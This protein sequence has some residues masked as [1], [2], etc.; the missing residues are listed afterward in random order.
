M[1]T[2]MLLACAGEPDEPELL[3]L[4]VDLPLPTS[5]YQIVTEPFEVG[6]YE[7]RDVCTIVR[8]EPVDGET[9]LWTDTLETLVSDN[10]HHMNV[11]IGQFSFLDPFLGEGASEDAL[12]MPIGQY[13]C[14]ELSVMESAFPVFPSQRD[15]QQITLPDGVAAPLLVPGLYVFS[16]H[17]VNASDTPV[18]VNAA[19]NVET[20]PADA[21]DQVASLVFDAIGGFEVPAGERQVQTR[22][23]VMDR[24]VSVALVSTHTHE[25]GECTALSAFDGQDVSSEPFFV[26]KDWEVP[27]ILHFEPQTFELAAG[28][29]IHYACHFDNDTERTLTVDGTAEGEMCVFAAVVY[30]AP[31]GVSEVEAVVEGGELDGLIELLDQTL[32]GC[33]D[34]AEA[35]S[36]W[37]EGRTCEPYAQTESNTLR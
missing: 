11:F 18:L 27:P 26:N 36:P 17:Y 7:E 30:P 29:G 6:A 15:N 23:C 33:P 1:T 20:V 24:D 25:W 4:T 31:L 35:P 16:H 22:T 9:L 14:D 21:V 37:D 12:G 34:H 3:D 28:E 10:T 2:L 19:L 32:G 5:G 8:M 13:D